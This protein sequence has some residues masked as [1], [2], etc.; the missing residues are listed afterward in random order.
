MYS[1]DNKFVDSHGLV[2]S[3]EEESNAE[4]SILWT[5][6]LFFLM[7]EK[8]RDTNLIQTSI[9]KAILNMNIGKGLYKQNPSYSH[10][11]NDP[12]DEAYVSHDQLTAIFSYAKV[13]NKQNIIEDIVDVISNQ[14]YLLYKRIHH[15]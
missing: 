6:E 1:L 13:T 10:P 5:I 15:Y 4:N 7:K 14:Y 3:R 11:K 9:D 8:G 2:N 12:S